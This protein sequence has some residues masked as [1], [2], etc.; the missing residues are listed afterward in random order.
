MSIQQ[1][2]IYIKQGTYEHTLYEFLCLRNYCFVH[3]LIVI[4]V[5]V[6][7]TFIRLYYVLWFHM[8]LCFRFLCVLFTH[9]PALSFMSLYFPHSLSCIH[10]R[11]YSFG[12]LSRLACRLSRSHTP[13]HSICPLCTIPVLLHYTRYGFEKPLFQQFFAFNRN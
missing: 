2:S 8:R 11:L 7:V 13:R 6:S 5:C 3:G 4:S 12:P 1:H 9:S 10:I